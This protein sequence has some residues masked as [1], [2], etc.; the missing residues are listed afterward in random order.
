[1]FDMDRETLIA[2]GITEEVAFSVGADD[3][4]SIEAR[5]AGHDWYYFS[6][7]D[8]VVHDTGEKAYKRI[9]EELEKLPVVTSLALWHEYAPR[10]F[11]FPLQVG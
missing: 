7:Q 11:L 1:M 5:L 6:D 10:R 4:V 2:L 3:D 8:P 9:I